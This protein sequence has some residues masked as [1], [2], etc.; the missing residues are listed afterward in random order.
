MLGKY[1]LGERVQFPGFEIEIAGRTNKLRELFEGGFVQTYWREQML[2]SQIR[3]RLFDVRPRRVLGQDRA[4][5]NFK[6]AIVMG[7]PML[8][9]EMREQ[10]I[11]NFFQTF[12]HRGRL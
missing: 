2:T 12:F 4:D 9:A 8:R 11:E 10:Q 5:D 7:P 6:I 1:K 3:H